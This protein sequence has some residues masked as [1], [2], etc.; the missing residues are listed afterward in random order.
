LGVEQAVVNINIYKWDVATVGQELTE[1]QV[2][3]KEMV[4]VVPED[5]TD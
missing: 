4:D 2:V 5:V 3:A 1:N